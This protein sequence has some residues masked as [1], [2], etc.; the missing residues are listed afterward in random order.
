MNIEMS[1]AT[2]LAISLV[3]T[4]LSSTTILENREN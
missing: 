3:I 1:E 4:M 2:I